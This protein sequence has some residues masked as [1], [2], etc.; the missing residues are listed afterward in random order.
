M[1]KDTPAP[2]GTWIFSYLAALCLAGAIMS[3]VAFAL[4][5]VSGPQAKLFAE[6]PKLPS[7]AWLMSTIVFYWLGANADRLG[8]RFWLLEEPET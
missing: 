7:W 3:L 4:I 2:I 1:H 6:A 5:V 8:D